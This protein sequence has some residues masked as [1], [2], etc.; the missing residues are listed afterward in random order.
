MKD[1]VSVHESL[2]T[3]DSDSEDRRAVGSDSIP[4][5]TVVLTALSGADL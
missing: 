3:S 1:K 4:G 5:L 2:R